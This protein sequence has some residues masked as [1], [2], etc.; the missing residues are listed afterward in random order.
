M[1]SKT[2]VRQAKPLTANDDKDTARKAALIGN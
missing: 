2:D 1:N